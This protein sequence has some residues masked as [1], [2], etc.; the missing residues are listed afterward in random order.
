MVEPTGIRIAPEPSTYKGTSVLFTVP[1]VVTPLTN[2]SLFKDASPSRY[3]LLLINAF[4]LNETSP[5]ILI[6][7]P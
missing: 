5:L 6:L 3:K 7:F 1:K 4:E 2:K